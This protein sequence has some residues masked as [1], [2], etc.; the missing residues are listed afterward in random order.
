[1]AIYSLRMS[2]VSRA[3]GQSAVSKAAYRAAEQLVDRTDGK[4]V[5]YE[6][7]AYGVADA[8]IVARDD[9]PA[10]AR[11]R[12]ELWNR[13]Q[14][15]EIRRNSQLAREL[16]I[17][18]PH[19][20]TLDQNRALVETFARELVARYGVAVD[21]A[22]HHPSRDG[23][24]RNIHAHLMMTTRP[25]NARGF[26]EK[27]RQLD[28]FA[29]R[30]DELNAIRSAWQTH[31]NEAL[32]VAGHEIQIDARSYRERGIAA[33]PTIH[34][35]PA[36]TAMLRR[37]DAIILPP[38]AWSH[39]DALQT[40]IDNPRD[41][42]ALLTQE[43]SV[44]TT[45]D[46]A[47][48]ARRYTSEDVPAYQAIIAAVTSL[49][50]VVTLSPEIRAGDQI[51]QH[52]AYTTQR[53]L[54][55]ELTMRADIARLHQTTTHAIPPAVA[56]RALDA[57][58]RNGGV[59]LSH[60]QRAAVDHVTANNGVAVVV[61]FAGAG[62][63]TTLGAARAVWEAGAERV[64]GAAVAGKA[65]AGL[66]ESAGI[67]S[68]TIASWTQAWS[69]GRDL[70]RAGDVMV[71]DE[72]GMAKAAD[73]ATFAATVAKADAKLVLVGDPDQLQPIGGGAAFRAI[74][75]QTGYVELA[76]IRR[77]HQ[78]WARAASIDFARGRMDAALSAYDQRGHVHLAG[79]RD[80]ARDNLARDYVASHDPAKTAIALAYTRADVAA[81]NSAIRAGL[82][83]R[84][85]LGASALYRTDA[86]PRPFAQGDRVLFLK[87]DRSGALKNGMT[88]MVTQARAGEL[89]IRIDGGKSVT[90]RDANYSQIAHGYAATVHKSQGATFDRAYVL[91]TKNMDRHMAY[92]AMTRHR[93]AA[94]LYAGRDE[95]RSTAEV[96][97]AFSRA[98]TQHTT[99]DYGAAAR[100]FAEN[101]NLIDPQAFAERIR[102]TAQQARAWLA[103]QREK[104]SET[105]TRA[106]EA[107]AAI[108]PAHAQA[109][110][111]ARDLFA[112]QSYD[113]APAALRVAV[114][115]LSP[116]AS[117]AVARIT[118][119]QT[120]EARAQAVAALARDRALA[121][122]LAKLAVAIDRRF[123]ERAFSADRFER[124]P[125]SHLAHHVVPAER[126]TLDAI[127]P[128]FEALQEARL[129][130]KADLEAVTAPAR[131]GRNVAIPGHVATTPLDADAHRRTIETPEYR[132]ARAEIAAQ[133][134]A[135]YRTP[136]PA[137]ARIEKFALDHSGAI[138]RVNDTIRHAPDQA[139]ALKGE[140][141]L[142]DRAGRAERAAAEKAV[143][144]L[145]AAARDL[146]AVYNL[147]RPRIEAQVVAERERAATP[148]PRLSDKAQERIAE[149]ATLA[150]KTPERVP[151]ALARLTADKDLSAEIANFRAAARHRFGA[152]IEDR[153]EARAAA[154]ALPK[155]QRAAFAAVRVTEQRMKAVTT[156]ARDHAPAKTQT[157]T[158][159]Q[160]RGQGPVLTM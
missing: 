21:C 84:G 35:G 39:A 88:G 124:I 90:I 159:Q 80:A 153:A 133:A 145:A 148:I 130:A 41:A 146:A 129:I 7:R 98:P 38:S 112:A 70:L 13:V 93:D 44:F 30:R 127:R 85:A 113:G 75:Q 109:P 89:T 56:A 64:L 18:L 97:A 69:Q 141:R 57:F 100:A 142:L 53:L 2:V 68:R 67:E 108:L 92:V 31:A 134:A 1:M 3:A 62:K 154:A 96:A 58:S 59:A 63:S 27:L 111:R 118:D 51:I 37:D 120:P 23:D 12:E 28:A 22:I 49:P 60:E 102:E 99:L 55:T 76:E 4:T 126:A 143:P 79:T 10:W 19:E 117:A 116:A 103:S 160:V 144:A 20:L 151:A 47:N 61:G 95:L 11:D 78:E 42:L 139:G 150:R 15:H 91:A 132:A 114:P 157:Q 105:W 43:R 147:Q 83:Q 71:V 155:D 131:P 77:Q 122:E 110:A 140:T 50:G 17:A 149:L 33:E 152:A 9:A 101:R 16:T 104:L 94:D 36:I 119:A 24:Q 5:D 66:Q 106:R 54:D 135:V 34:K 29:T 6:R 136:A 107:V 82:D 123:G 32:L 86:G 81:L 125:T 138:E 40:L 14:E 26:G 46:L 121:P 87:N 156:A 52:A 115:A 72:A 45:A 48:L 128:T 25:I 74:A 65:A 137:V 158:Q 8:F 73:L